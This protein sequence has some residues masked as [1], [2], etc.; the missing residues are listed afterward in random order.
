[1]AG[2]TTL[3]KLIQEE[4][5]Q[6]SEEGCDISGFDLLVAEAQHDNARLMEIYHLLQALPVRDDF[7]Y[8]EPSDLAAIRSERPEGPRQLVRSHEEAVWQ[9][10]FFGAWLGRCVGCALGKPLESTAFA[11]GTPEMP[12]WRGRAQTPGWKNI[13]TWFEAANMWPIT[14]Y[15]P[16]QSPAKDL[17]G[18]AL[19]SESGLSER[20]RIAYMQSDDDIRYTILG[21]LMIEE[22]GVNFDSWDI[23]KLW[24]RVLPYQFVCTAE[25]QAYLNFSAITSHMEGGRPHDWKQQLE[26]V[27]TYLNPYREWIGAQI[28]A[29]GWGYAAAGRPELAAELAWR[30]AS[31]SHVKNGIYGAMFIASMIAAAFVEEDIER[32][33]QIGLSE[34][35]QNCRLAH[36]VR[37]AIAIAHSTDNVEALMEALWSA[38]DHYHP[39]HTNNNAALVV[40]ALIFSKGDFERAITTAVLGGWDTDCNGATVG[41]IMGARLGAKVLPQ[42][43]VEPL[44]DTLYADLIGFDPIAISECARRSYAASFVHSSI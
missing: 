21:L 9:D 27:R 20:E 37:T 36:D 15:T 34:I 8:V 1:M 44:H 4:I 2:W 7:P 19:H 38:F 17:P 10:K 18:M 23:G 28:R 16:G 12:G 39:V 35:P 26:W 5:I 3:V 11:H 6:R 31:F 22:K 32:I 14:G 25:T 42:S 29:D 40:A 43:W 24:H 30:D 13:K 33:I 41:S